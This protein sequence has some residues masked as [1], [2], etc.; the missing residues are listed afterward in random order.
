MLG[1]RT[2]TMVLTS[3]LA[4]GGL[5]SAA[6]AAAAPKTLRVSINA[7]G[8]QANG[9][10][11]SASASGDG[12]FVAFASDASNLVPRDRNGA[13]DVFVR[14]LLTRAVQRVS[15]SS[16]GTEANGPSMA[17]S[18]DLVAGPSISADGR[19]V[20]FSSN[21]SNLVPGDTNGTEDCFV[22][23]LGTHTTTR[24][25]V[26]SGGAHGSGQCLQPV[27]SANGRFV[28]FIS[29][30]RLVPSASSGT[31]EVFVRD[32][33]AHRTR[34]V[35][36]SSAGA[37][38]NGA[39]LRPAISAGGRSVAFESIASNL[40][41]GDTNS[42]LDV[43]LYST[44]TG[45][46]QRLSV[47]TDGGQA[48]GPSYTGVQPS[49][50]LTGRYVVFYTDATNLVPG[51][52]NLSFDVIVRDLKG[53]TTRRVSVSSASVQ[54]NDASFLP[55]ITAD[56]REIAFESSASNL[57]PG[58]R[59]G[60]D[61]VFLRDL[62]TGRTQRLSRTSGGNLNLFAQQYEHASISA[63]G[64]YVAFAS[65]AGNLVAGDSNGVEDVFRAGPLH[66]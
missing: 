45:R 49:I 5:A 35:S 18:L 29:S 27:I 4:S 58:D 56:G 32:L 23:D 3:A 59:P 11:L 13:R 43:F 26:G 21:A 12:R 22:R 42:A 57:S 19:Y 66:P 15:V 28:A 2:A 30:S 10:S 55:S 44:A 60:T 31:P 33:K 14:D 7:S 40:V 24:V 39:S 62:R 41:S 36:V 51:D 1:R 64:R 50:S 65:L 17:S 8:R 34:L 16:R 52:T 9:A 63:D 53:H 61:E 20:T 54:G 38:A 47:T 46:I 6:V 48:N 25:S 37:A